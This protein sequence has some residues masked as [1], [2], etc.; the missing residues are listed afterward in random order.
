MAADG[1]GMNDFAISGP[2]NYLT[3]GR[4]I[5]IPRML[6]WR[7]HR[8]DTSGIGPSNQN[9]C[10]LNIQHNLRIFG[11]RSETIPLCQFPCPTLTMQLHPVPTT[12]YDLNFIRFERFRC[13][14]I[15]SLDVD[16]RDETVGRQLIMG[17]VAGSTHA[18]SLSILG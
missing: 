16:T 6:N 3:F 14:D 11:F 8:F 10:V 17:G 9:P 12:A 2:H 18:Y 15:S 13:S 7:S 4:I 1:A 5:S